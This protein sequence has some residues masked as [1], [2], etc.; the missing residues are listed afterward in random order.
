MAESS[1]VVEGALFS[2]RK[3]LILGFGKEDE[4]SIRA[5][6]E[7]NAG[8]VLLQENKGIADYAVV[9]LLGNK[10]TS[11]VGDVVTNTWLVS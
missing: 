1:S 6:I 8:K 10:V 2:G 4:S 7:E 9:P 3:F 5:L 11:F